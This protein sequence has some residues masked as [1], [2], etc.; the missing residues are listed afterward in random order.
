MSRI[1]AAPFAYL[2]TRWSESHAFDEAV[3]PSS[4]PLLPPEP[5]D[6]TCRPGPRLMTMRKPHSLEAER[7][8][9]LRHSLGRRGGVKDPRV[10][11]VSSAG[12]GEGKTTTAINLAV[13]L[14]ETP[15]S[16]VLLI[17]ADLRRPSVDKQLGITDTSRLGLGEALAEPAPR[18]DRY[19]HR[20]APYNLYLLSA[21]GAPPS[22]ADD[23]GSPQMRE[24]IRQARESYHH[25]V[26]DTPPLLAVPD[27]RL[28]EREADGILLVVTAHKT[29]RKPLEECLEMI[30]PDKIL[31][32]VLNQ[33]DQWLA[34]YGNNY[35]FYYE[36]RQAPRATPAKVA[37][38]T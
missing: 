25:V 23:L 21:G 36:G 14:A 35:R 15:R 8:R 7:Y 22:P 34:D 30:D 16:R 32:L 6:L 13:V 4:D 19:V 10:V 37:Q 17:D 3:E 12:V 1:L 18:L 38:R 5:A 20:L 2:S 28:I 29:L 24:L 26:I 9:M 33:D 31:G 11:A 27:A